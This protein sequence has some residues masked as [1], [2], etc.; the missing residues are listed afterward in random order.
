MPLS[1]GSKGWINKY[2]DLLENQS[3]SLS[4]LPPENIDKKTN[5]FGTYYTYTDNNNKEY[6][7]ERRQIGTT[8]VFDF[9]KGET[10]L[11]K[12]EQGITLPYYIN[13]QNK[14][15]NGKGENRL[16]Y[17]TQTKKVYLLFEKNHQKYNV[18][19]QLYLS[20]INSK[21]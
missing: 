12:N 3:I 21:N 5:A 14:V 6:T 8:S 1:P 9:F 2:F 16:K 20:L 7:C 15:F 4:I 18:L 17:A 19:V 13:N 11:K 10:I